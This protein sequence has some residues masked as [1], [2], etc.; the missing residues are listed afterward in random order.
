MF[1]KFWGWYER[2]EQLNVGIAAGLFAL[3]IFRLH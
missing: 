2:N 1:R 3:Q